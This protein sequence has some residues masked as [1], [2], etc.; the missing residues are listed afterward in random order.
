ME[1]FA[2]KIE[3]FDRGRRRSVLDDHIICII[4]SA[5]VG[6]LGAL[7]QTVLNQQRRLMRKALDEDNQ[8]RPGLQSKR[9]VG[10][11]RSVQ[12]QRLSKIIRMRAIQATIAV[13]KLDLSTKKTIKR[14]IKRSIRGTLSAPARGPAADGRSIM[15][16]RR[17]RRF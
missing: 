4:C 14:S 11:F 12:I 3:S 2:W 16:L 5:I 1:T 13:L 15:E 6:Q 8:T 10:A 17:R 7:H 9:T